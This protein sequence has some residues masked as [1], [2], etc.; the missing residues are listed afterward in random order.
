MVLPDLSDQCL[1]RSGEALTDGRHGGRNSIQP[2]NRTP[3]Y[4]SLFW[5]LASLFVFSSAFVFWVRF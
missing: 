1:E 5:I 3:N 4:S 2:N